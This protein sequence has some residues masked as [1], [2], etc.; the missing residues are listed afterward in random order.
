[1][2]FLGRKA[3]EFALDDDA[4]ASGDEVAEG[5]GG[6]IAA[7]VSPEAGAGES[8]LYSF[9]PDASSWLPSPQ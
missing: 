3:A 5:I 6:G 1:M 4:G 7:D 2:K 8:V 9:I